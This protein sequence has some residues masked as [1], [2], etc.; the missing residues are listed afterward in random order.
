MITIGDKQYRNLE[1]QVKKN[2]DDIQYILEEEG[3]LNELGINVVG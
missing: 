2:M 3:V 1:E